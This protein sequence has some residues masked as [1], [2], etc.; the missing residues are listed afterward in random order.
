MKPV[1][2]L[3]SGMPTPHPTGHRRGR[4]IPADRTPFFGCSESDSSAPRLWSPWYILSTRE[5]GGGTCRRVGVSAK[6][7]GVVEWVEGGGMKERFG[8]EWVLEWWS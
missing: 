3:A 7:N 8:A 4:E 1:S 5:G 2:P 6:G